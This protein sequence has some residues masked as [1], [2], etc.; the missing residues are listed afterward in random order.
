MKLLVA[1]IGL[2][3]AAS[4]CNPDGASAPSNVNDPIVG[5]SMKLPLKGML[6]FVSNRAGAPHI[7]LANPDG[8]DIRRLTSDTRS[9]VTPAWSRDGQRLAYV[10]DDGIYVV[11]RD[12]SNRIRIPGDGSS[13]SWSPDGRSLLLST[14]NGFKVVPADGSDQDT[15]L[16]AHDPYGFTGWFAWGVYPGVQGRWSPDGQRIAFYAYTDS[17]FGRVFMVDIDGTN[18]HSFFPG[19]NQLVWDECG[20]EWS[21]NGEQIAL[22]SMIHGITIL[23]LRTNVA[24]P[25]APSGTTCGD[26]NFS[27]VAWSPDATMLAVSKRDPPWIQGQRTPPQTSS[28]EIVEIQS[29]TV[30]AVIADAYGP[31]WSR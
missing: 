3:A 21:P 7:Y 9:E 30:R 13:P 6:A 2:A 11:D 29:R 8:T 17:D 24:T 28:I 25:I 20:P 22:L 16:I 31:A 5:P 27:R 14:P 19:Q 4:A 1:T 23:D 15:R 18:G 26:G 10:T 12:G